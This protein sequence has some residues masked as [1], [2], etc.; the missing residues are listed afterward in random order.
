MNPS[1]ARR[2]A[3][4]NGRRPPGRGRRRG[5]SALV[6]VPVFLFGAF[7]ALA[8]VLVV[9]VVGAFVAYSQGLPDPR[10]LNDV[11]DLK[12]DSIIYARDGT[13]EL[14]RFNS[15]EH[16]EVV[17]FDQLSADLVDATT[18]V[19]DK[20]FWT[21][22]GFDPLAIASA[23][24]DSASGNVRGASTITQQLVRQRLL[25]PELVQD[26]KKKIER[27]IKEIIQSIRLT[28][29]FPGEQ[30]KQQI[31]TAYLNQNFYGNNAY[32]VKAAAQSYFGK[33][34]K[35]LTLAQA[36]ILAGI[37]QSP[38]A[39]D[40]VRN[41]AED[42][43]GHLIVPADSEI[44]LRRNFILDLLEKDAGRCHLTCGKHSSA[45]YEAAKLELVKLV[46]QAPPN[47]T[48]P[49]FI[50]YVRAELADKLCAGATTCPE[51]ERGGMKVITTL[52][53][54]IQKV[55]EKWTKATATMAHFPNPQQQAADLKIPYTDWLKNL[56]NQN[57]WNAAVSAIDYQTGEIIA[58]VGS[59]DYYASRKVNTRFQP[60][61]DVLANGWRQPGSAFKPFNYATGID[62]RS[63]TAATMLMDVSTDFGGGYVPADADSLERGPLRA[64]QALQFS[65]NIPAIK[66]LDMNGI[67]RVFQNAKAFGMNFQNNDQPN[68]G[69]TMTLGTLEVHPVDLASSYATLANG[70]LHI[71]R[72]SI[73]QVVGPDSKDMIP[74]YQPPA[75][76]HVVSTQAAGI[77]T[78][79]LAG[80]TD[81][82][83][84]PFWG[85]WEV[86]AK[87]GAHRPATLKTGTN[88][89]AKDL[90]AYGYIAPPSKAERAAGQYALVIGAWAGNSDATP[91]STPGRQALASLDVTAPLWSA[92]MTEITRNWGV[93]DF[94]RP[95][96]I[97]EAKVDAHTGYRPSQ[98]SQAQVTELFIKGT[99]PGDDPYIKGLQVIQAPDGKF[100]RWVNGCTGTPQT[101]GYLDL[102]EA[103]KGRAKW[104]DANHN[105]I[106]RAR[107]GPGVSG[108]ADP[109][110]PNQTAYFYNGSYQPY[111]AT[112]G[113]PFAPDKDCNAAP[114][115]SP[116]P[117]AS[118]SASPSD[119]P[120]PEPSASP[121]VTPAVT[122]EITPPPVT[123]PPVSPP[124]VT[125]PPVT[126]PPVTPP[127]V[128]PPHV[129]PRP[130]T[131][132]PVTPPP[133]TAPPATPAPTAPPV[134]N[135]P[136]PT[137]PPA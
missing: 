94:K 107:K 125:P 95:D 46:P 25:P 119:S 40:L 82:N 85:K 2:Q 74:A 44:V 132:P 71:A 21:N 39:Y 109:A 111:G 80:N 43:S 135:Q 77:L 58:Y 10:T 55:A 26:P 118:P 100:Y 126:P 56:R 11:A 3:N 110:H 87:G 6:V 120:S 83:A 91:V 97:V 38:V 59:G 45:D 29:A 67:D 116:S 64:R 123:P 98:Y 86:K 134:Q 49:H 8:L 79:M 14:A 72:T 7:A 104:Q 15:G 70:G 103:D 22:T 27:K 37:P 99:E 130:P 131:P 69:L 65:L 76:D 42:A 24:L 137:P 52:D 36:A 17:T 50:W 92:V 12:G 89:D 32:G 20:T 63:M 19:E 54:S 102:T 47:W 88:D 108:G 28:Q 41:A 23:A 48:A 78:D 124:P 9:G 57:V 93:S 112:W 101:K 61:F 68:A 5:R 62:D 66:A 75:G 113:A 96:G 31:I 114:S 127:P 33:N 51:L 60:Q 35:D 129:T 117:S 128:T 84:N 106:Q 13:T 30:G 4:R 90:N 1:L 115:P 34:L 16:R 133:V 18:A 121:L 122:P 136:T 81:P 105:W 73:L 53:P